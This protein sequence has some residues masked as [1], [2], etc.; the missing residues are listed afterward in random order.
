MYDPKA[1]NKETVKGFTFGK[2]P[3]KERSLLSSKSSA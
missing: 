2:A 3:P 1:T